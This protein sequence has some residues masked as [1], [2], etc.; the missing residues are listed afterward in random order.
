MGDLQAESRCRRHGVL[1]RRRTGPGSALDEQRRD[2]PLE[3]IST[4][5]KD[6]VIA[7]EDH[8]FYLHPGDRS[9]CARRV[10]LLYNLRSSARAPRA[11]APSRSS[12]RGRCFSRTPAHTHG[13]LQ[14]AALAVLL[15]IFLIKTRDPRAL[16]QSHLP[17]AAAST[18]SS[19]CRKRCCGKPASELTLAEAALI[20][21]II[22]APAV[23]FAVDALRH[24]PRG[25]ASSCCSGCARK[26]DHGRAGA[27]SARRADPH[28]PAAA[29]RRRRRG[30][31]T[32]RN[33]CG[34]SSATSTAATIRRTG[35]CTR[36]FVPEIQDAAEAAVRDGLR[37]LGGRKV[38]RRRSSRWIRRPATCSRWSAARTSRSTPFN[39][40]IRSRRQP[41]SAF[42]PFVYAAA[43]ER[44]LSPVSTISGIR[45][46]AIEAP[47]GRVDSPRRARQRAGRADAAR[48]AARIEQRRRRAAAAAGRQSRPVLRLANDLGVSRSA[49]RAVAGA[50]QRPRHAARSDRGLRRVSDARLS[51]AAARARRRCRTPTATLRASQSTSNA[52]RCSRRRSRFRW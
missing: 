5:F 19:R 11:A 6:A 48:G 25:A 47:A 21:G 9:D 49:R 28:R 2:V 8:R 17:R 44:G 29:G 50:R 45:Q 22:R 52:S 35:R 51:R 40:A 7:V 42:K 30:T 36:R 32:R 13:R 23:V 37:R 15:E 41:G 24:R 10:P 38:C 3:Q 14:E 20:A 12:S 39:R 33:T 31:A 18:A 4:Y 34:S 26:E 46:V 16:H 1:R 27:G 43:L